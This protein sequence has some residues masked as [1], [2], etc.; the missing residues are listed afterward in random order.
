M[1]TG[2]FGEMGK[3]FSNLL[4]KCFPESRQAARP[5]WTLGCRPIRPKSIIQPW[6]F[7]ATLQLSFIYLL[8]PSGSSLSKYSYILGI[9]LVISFEWCVPTNLLNSPSTSF[10]WNIRRALPAWHPYYS[11]KKVKR[12]F[13]NFEIWEKV[14]ASVIVRCFLS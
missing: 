1:Q 2:S 5:Q 4:D 13:F 11:I 14:L 7:L 12:M 6:A 10:W 8:P 3:L 9:S